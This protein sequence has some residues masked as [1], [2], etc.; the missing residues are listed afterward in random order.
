VLIDASTRLGG[1]QVFPLGRLRE[2]PAG[3]ARAHLILITRSELSDLT[4]VIERQLRRW[5]VCAPVFRAAV[6]PLAWVEHRT[7]RQHSPAERPFERAGVFCGLGNPEA[8]RR[9]LERMGVEPVAWLD[10]EDTT[11]TARA[12]C[13]ASRTKCAPRAPPR[14]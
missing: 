1:G 12:S 3:L 11:A 10:F 8:F 2:P 4:A 7:G 9:T 13:A 6:E 14:W 5:N